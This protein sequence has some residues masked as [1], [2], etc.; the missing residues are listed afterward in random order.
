ML[1][2]TE[3]SLSHPAVGL[4]LAQYCTL[5]SVVTFHDLRRGKVLRPSCGPCGTSG[6]RVDEVFLS[7]GLEE[8]PTYPSSPR[9]GSL[10]CE[11]FLQNILPLRLNL[12]SLLTHT[13]SP[14]P[15][16]AAKIPCPELVVALLTYVRS[17]LRAVQQDATA[18]DT[19]STT[20]NKH[21]LE[22]PVCGY[23]FRK[24]YVQQSVLQLNLS[25]SGS[26]LSIDTRH[27]TGKR[28][29][30]IH[31]N[32]GRRKEEPLSS[33]PLHSKLEFTKSRGAF[34][35]PSRTKKCLVTSLPTS[36]W[37]TSNLKG[38]AWTTSAL[39]STLRMGLAFHP[40]RAL[41][42][43]RANRTLVGISATP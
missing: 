4:S 41:L 31:S 16:H 19:A 7:T 24:H 18:Q 17:R 26:Y 1:R 3:I 2:Y 8:S 21:I 29:F 34:R 38:P 36:A 25:S 14:Y 42:E 13:Y 9:Q 37:P 10:H 35:Q 39:H 28:T 33:W 12:P 30:N 40:P 32:T 20:I 27:S 15:H 6:A 11:A 22:K 5:L 43:S 23:L